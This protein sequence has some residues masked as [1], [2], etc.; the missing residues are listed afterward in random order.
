[1]GVID[2]SYNIENIN[3]K[4]AAQ[5]LYASGDFDPRDFEET[6]TFHGFIGLHE[7]YYGKRVISAV[8]GGERYITLPASLPPGRKEVDGFRGRA[9]NGITD[10]HMLGFGASW[11]P[12]GAK[13]R[14][15][16]LNPNVV[17]YWKQHDSY[18]YEIDV[19]DSSNNGTS[20]TER[21]RKFLGTEFN[22]YAHYQ[23][24]K[25]L[26]LKGTVA[27]FIPGSFFH[28]IK[29]V[30]CQNDYYLNLSQV[31]RDRYGITSSDLYKYRLGTDNALFGNIIL[32]Y[33][34]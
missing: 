13:K 18:K 1:M 16:S 22:L 29:G 25:G 7:L 10:M 15:F 4:I 28:D 11:Y 31:Q 21:A 33:E 2:V 24:L 19:Q 17:F 30:P 14:N 9:Y 32:H 8:I 34:F 6:K 26:T 23:L 20:S 12:E 3:V 5:Y 27:I